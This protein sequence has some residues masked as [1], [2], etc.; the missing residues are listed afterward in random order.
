MSAGELR[1]LLDGSP[2]HCNAFAAIDK[3]GLPDAWLAAGAI[4][5]LVWDERFGTGFDPAR[6][7]DLDVIYFGD[8]D[9]EAGAE[10]ELNRLLPGVRWQV[11]NQATVHLWYADRFGVEVEPLKDIAEAVATFPETATAVAANATDILAPLGLDDLLN[12]VWRHNP[13]RCTVEEARRRLAAKDV[14][15]RWPGVRVV[16]F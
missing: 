8:H 2:F 6:V 4:R 3:L 16:R 1:A 11:K 14:P 10:A 12:G 9:V 7:K 15:T 5:D 13:V